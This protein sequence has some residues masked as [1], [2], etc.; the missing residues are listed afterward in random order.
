M[1]FDLTQPASETLKLLA[2]YISYI[3]TENDKETANF[4]LKPTCFH[5]RTLP[6][7][8]I[9]GY[10]SRILKYSPCGTEVF[11]AQLVYIRRLSVNK[12]FLYKPDLL[13]FEGDSSDIDQL[14]S[15]LESTQ[16]SPMKTGIVVDSYNI[17]RLLIT[18]SLV[19]IKFLSD[20]FYTNLHVSRTEQSSDDLGV[21]GVPL[22][23]LNQMELEFLK[24]SNFSLMV[25]PEE[26]IEC[27]DSLL[28]F[29]IN[30]RAGQAHLQSEPTF[31]QS[32]Q[33]ETDRYAN[34]KL[35]SSTDLSPKL[36]STSNLQ[37]QNSGG[38][39]I[40]SVP[41][42]EEHSSRQ[43]SL[44]YLAVLQEK[45]RNHQLVSKP[46]FD[47]GSTLTRRRARMHISGAIFAPIPSA[48][49][50]YRSRDAN[51]TKLSKIT[52]SFSK[53]VI[54]PRCQCKKLQCRCK[55]KR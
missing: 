14:Q 18:S 36:F 22:N 42:T 47:R 45:I 41:S 1:A 19:A 4:K 48:P 55:T 37:K 26:L 46:I 35:N 30:F 44:Q 53:I 52:K 38:P 54:R 21:G 20:V 31:I 10:L 9:L 25:S 7:I 13:P 51:R 34:Q 29:S 49:I 28:L 33:E 40:F 2:A 3:S 5:A 12:N 11:L 50:R 43:N 17:H 15:R 8:D 23:E 32:E 16:I 27:G 24:L 6:S 39:T